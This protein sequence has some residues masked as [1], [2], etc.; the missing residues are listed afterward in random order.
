[1]S[2]L[3]ELADLPTRLPKWPFSPWSTANLIRRGEL[4]CVRVGRRV[5]VTE[6]LLA[7][8]VASQTVPARKSG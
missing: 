7:E 2:D 5:F 6:E 3:I 4:G 8:F 1:M